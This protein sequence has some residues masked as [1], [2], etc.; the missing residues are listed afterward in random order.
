MPGTTL[1]TGVR[2]GGSGEMTLRSVCGVQAPAGSSTP[3]VPTSVLFAGVVAGFF[4]VGS[5]LAKNVTVV[6]LAPMRAK[7]LSQLVAPMAEKVGGKA[8]GAPR[9]CRY[10]LIVFVKDE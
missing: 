7:N 6:R 5:G 2:L 3:S 8:R 4:V 9:K 10:T 1:V